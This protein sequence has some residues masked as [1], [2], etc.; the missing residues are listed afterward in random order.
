MSRGEMLRSMSG[1]NRSEVKEPE[2]KK[3]ATE[4]VLRAEKETLIA[5][6]TESASEFEERI[7]DQGANTEGLINTLSEILGDITRAPEDVVLAGYSEACISVLLKHLDTSGV[8]KASLEDVVTSKLLLDPASVARLAG[9]D[10]SLRAAHHKVQVL[11]RAEVHWLL[12]S[13]VSHYHDDT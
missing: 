11:L 13:Q 5:A 4:A 2:E 8:S 9:E 1:I 7:G 10:T 6:K 3:D 12:A